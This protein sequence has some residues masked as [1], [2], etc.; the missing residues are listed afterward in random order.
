MTDVVVTDQAFGGVEQEHNTALTFGC[1]FADYQ[2]HTEQETVEIASGARIL[3]VN[4]APITRT[5]LESLDTAAVVIRY[6]IGYDNVDIQA[7]RD[8]GIRV[9]NVPDYGAD[10]VADHTV[11]MLLAT[12]RQLV[13]YN[14]AIRRDGWVE[15]A[16]LGGI[17]GFAETTVGL[18]GTGRIGKAVAARLHPFG[19]RI[20]AYDPFVDDSV[21]RESGII[22]VSLTELLTASDAISLHAPLTPENRHLIGADA[23]R[24]MRRGAV[25]VN[26]SRGGLLDEAAVAAALND[27]TIR[28]AALDVFEDEPL[29]SYSP[30]RNHPNAIFTPHAAFFS[31][32]SLTNLQR[33]AA[34]EGARALGGQPLRCIVS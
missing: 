8:L 29:P 27:G 9:C 13:P 2:V 11:A 7:A 4:F 1:T 21:T 26:T 23:L 10:T 18:I 12:L 3:F 6:G 28:A 25:I 34:E 24:Q 33:L 15:P 30:L 22:L 17:R 31:D 5:V 16:A 14:D 32:V 20:L 19:F